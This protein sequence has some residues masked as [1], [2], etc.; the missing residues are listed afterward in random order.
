M[1]CNAYDA[2]E[3]GKGH[4]RHRH[5]DAGTFGHE[6]VL[7]AL[8]TTPFHQLC[9]HDADG[10]KVEGNRDNAIENDDAEED[11]D[12]SHVPLRHHARSRSVFLC[13]RC[14]GFP[15]MVA[16][17]PQD[18]EIVVATIVEDAVLYLGI[19]LVSI[20]VER[21]QFS[22]GYVVGSYIVLQLLLSL[23]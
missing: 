14:L 1:S 10:K 16:Y 5:N 19:S 9:H 15:V 3:N 6:V 11:E 7:D 17:M 13:H 4:D 12:D 20:V 18:S 21:L 22:L 23:Y 8:K 2:Q